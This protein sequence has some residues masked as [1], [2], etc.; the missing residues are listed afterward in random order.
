MNDLISTTETM[1]SIQISEMIGKQHKDILRDIRDEA[2]KLEAGGID[3]ERK[4]ALSSY[5]TE[6]NKELPCYILTRE[7]ILQLAARYDA[8]TR[9]KLIEMAM[10]SQKPRTLSPLEIMHQMTGALLEQD[11]Q[12]KQLTGA[13]QDMRDVIS[14]DPAG[15]RDD[16]AKMVNRI[17]IKAGGTE[18][19]KPVWTEVHKLID[20]RM[21][22][23]LQTRL[24]NKRRRMADEGVCKSTRD[25]T[26]VMDIIGEDK[27][28]IECCVHVVKQL[29]IKNGVGVV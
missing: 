9:A 8:V 1:T 4:F 22:V 7:G 23:D 6:Q 19:I 10:R 11:R 25:K 12:L 15:W 2:E 17:A 3:G 26:N 24:T 13:M 16:C 27:K 21:G 20:K 28:L 5:M 18:H 29:A 14:L